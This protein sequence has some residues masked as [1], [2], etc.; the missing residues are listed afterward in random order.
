MNKPVKLA[1]IL[2]G[3]AVSFETEPIRPPNVSP[4]AELVIL[5]DGCL[6]LGSDVVTERLDAKGYA[7]PL[8]LKWFLYDTIVAHHEEAGIGPTCAELAKLVCEDP[9]GPMLILD[10]VHAAVAELEREGGPFPMVE[11]P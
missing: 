11:G 3:S 7:V 4:E 1:C 2:C 8:S 6:A 10:A 5:C 9:R